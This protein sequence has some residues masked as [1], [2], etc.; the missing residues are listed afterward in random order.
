MGVIYHCRGPMVIEDFFFA[1][2]SFLATPDEVRKWRYAL[3]DLT[4]VKSMDIDYADVS[5]VVTQNANI[6]TLAVPG[7]LSSLG[8]RISERSWVRPGPH[9]G[10]AR[11]T[12]WLGDHDLSLRRSSRGMDSEEDPGKIRNRSHES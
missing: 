8:G 1:N 12:C 5:R 9:V 4:A 6:A 2:A 3:I 11:R 10:S 7:V